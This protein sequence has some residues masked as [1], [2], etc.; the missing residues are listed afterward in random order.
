[1][2][3]IRDI[4][5]S[6][7]M[8]KQIPVRFGAMLVVRFRPHIAVLHGFLMKGVCGGVIRFYGYCRIV[9]QNSDEVRREY[10]TALVAAL[11]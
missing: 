1:M 3:W 4:L 9:R 11:Q 2:G 6:L 5:L 7:K 10:G 8:V